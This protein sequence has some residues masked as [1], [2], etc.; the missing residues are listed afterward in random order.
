M[1]DNDSD[2]TLTITDLLGR[3][4]ASKEGKTTKETSLS[5]TLPNQ[6]IY[7]VSFET[8]GQTHTSKIIVK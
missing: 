1:P 4:I 7:L 2:Y 3:R 6:G 5:I 8:Q